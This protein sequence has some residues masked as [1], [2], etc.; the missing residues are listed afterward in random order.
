MKKNLQRFG[1]SVLAAAMV[2][3]SVALPAA[4]ETTKIDSSVAQSVAASAA[5]A[6]SAVQS[7][8]KF[9]S[10]ADLIKQTAQTL[11]AQGEVHELE[12]DDAKLEATAQ[13]KAGMSL[14]ALEN[15][16]ADAMY[17]NAAAGKINTEAYGLN[18]DEMASVMAA[19]IKTYHLSSAVTDLGYETNAAGVVTAVTFTGSSGMTSAM[20]SMTNSDDEVIA[21]QAD[22]YAQAYVAENSDTFAA[23]A[24]ADGHTYGEPKWYWNDTNPEDGHTHT[25]KETPDGY[26][27]KTDDGWAYTAVYT[28]KE[29]DAY[30]K[31]EGTV[32]KD[33]TEAKPGAAGKTVYS[34][35]VPADKSP[36]KKEYKEPTTRTDDIA[37][38][39]C[40]NHAVPKDA[41]GNFVA[42]FNWEM[43]KVEG[44]LEADYSNAQLFYDS[45]TGKISASAPVTIDWE[46]TSV[47]FKCAV[48]GE[49]IKT[50]PVMTMPVSVVVDQNNNS[51]Y[52]N[53]GGT[54]TLD[55]TSGGTG[56]TLVSAMDGGNWYDM[57]NNPVDASKVNFTY[58]S[59]DNK[60]KNSLLL[61]DS[62]KTAVYVDDQ[63]NQV[64]N[65]YDV[66]TAQMNY[67]YFQLSQ[68][69]QDEAEYFGVVAPFWTSKGVQKQGEDG[70]ITGTM[71][72]I[73]VLCSM[74][75]NDDVPPTTMAFMLNMLPQAFMAYV[76]NYG[77]ALKAI[78]DA[79]LAQVA[80]LG[81]SA[82]YVTKLLILHDWISQVAEFDMGS[83]GDITGGGNNDP[84]QMT[85]FGALLGG[86]IGASGVEYGCICLGYASAFNYM[87]QNLPDNKS[88]YKNEDG[89]WKTPDEVGDN[90]VVDFAQILYYCNT[91]DTSVAG[92]AFGGGMFNNVHY[93][94]AVKVNKLQGDSNSAT[95]TTGEAN[96]NWYYVDVC[97]DD[98]NT[99][100]MAQTRVE[101][102]GDLRHV[103]FLVSPSG[104]EG[105]YSK[106]YDYIDSLYDGYTY[107]KNKNPDVDDDGNVVLNNGKPHYSYT[108]TENK[109][110]TRYTDTCYEDTWFTSICSPIY[111]DN[112]Y[113]YYV[114]TTT[115]QNLYNNMRRQQSENGNNGN[116]GSGSSGNNSQMQQFMKKMQ[117]QGP[118]TLEARPRN[119]NYYIRK[120][121]SSSRPGGFSMS[122]FTKTDDPFDIVLMYYNDLKETSSNFNDDDSNAKVLAEA[123]TIYKIDT[124]AKDKHA[125][126]E[127]NLNTECLADAAAKR[128]YPALVHSTALYDGKLYFNVNNA[129]YRMDPTTGTV[130]EVKEY[131]TVYGGIK[132]TK[133]KDGNMVPDTHFPGMSM[134]IMDSAQDTSSVKYLGTFKNHPLA[135]LTL[136]DSYSFAT[137]T[138]QKQTV[139]TGINTTKDQLVVSVGTNLSNTY[140]SLDELDSDGKPVVKTDV[141][142]TSYANRKSY[143]TESWNYNPSYNQN[144]GS[145][146]EK[147]K[148]EEFM[149]CAN[150]VETMPMS[151]MVSD[152][153]SGA[154]TDVSVEAWCDTPAYTQARTTKY[155]L[156]KGK[157]VYADN[158]L[159][160]GH[161]W[162]LDE[163][164][165]KSVGNN[166][167]LCSDC[168]T[169]TES[170][171]HTV[172]LPDA[173]AGVTLTLGTTSNTYIKDDTV[174]LTVE[175]EGTDI[176]T[177][178]AKNGDTEVALTEVQEAA[179]DEAAAQA[180]T[181]K[182]KTVY[183]FTMPDGDVTISVEKNAKTYEVK[184]AETTNGKLEISPATAAE[185]ATVT[186]KVTPDAGY[187]LK[188]NG[189][190]VT[191]TDA[192][193]KE[194]TVEVKAGTEANTYT[195][196][197]PAYP[198]NVS[199]EFAKEYKVTVADT[200]NK[201]GETKVSATA[202]VVGTEVTV[203]VKAADNYQLKADSLTYSYKSGEDTKTEKL[204][205]NAE[206]KATFKMPAADVKVT[207]EY[208]EKK[209]EAYT[210]TVNK[211][212]NGTVTV[213]KATNGTVTADKETAAAGDTVTL[214]VEADETMYS[215]AVLAEDGLKV[216]DSKGAAVACTAG[217]DGTYTFTMP[218]DN[219]TVTATFEIVAYGVEVAP[220][221]HGSVTFEGGKKYFKVGENVTATFTAEAGYELASASYQEGNKPTDITAKVKEASN[222]YTF[223]MPENYVKIEATF[224]AVQ[225]TEPTE[226]TEPTTPDENGGDNTETEALEAEERTVHGAAE[227]TTITAMAV[228]TCTD[229]NCASA[230]FVDATVKQTSGVTTAAVNFNGKDYTAKY[231]EKNGW[232]EENGKKYWYEKGVKQG[233]TGRGKEIYD[234]DSDAWYW[235][236]A[237]QGG[238]MT[239]S[240][241]VYQ[242]SAAGQWAD[243]PDGTGKWVRYDENGHMVKGWQTTDKGTYYFDLITGAMAKG[244]GDIDGVPCAFDE[245]TGIAL[246]GQWLTIKGADF[247]YEKGVRQGLDGRGKEIYD[248]ASDAWYWLD[249]VDQGKKATSKDVYQESEAGQWADR[250]DGTGKWL[251]YD[252]QGHMIKGWSADKRYYFDPIYGTMAKGDA[253][254]D[255]RTY[256]FDKNTGVL[257]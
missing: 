207:A 214:T 228:F 7:L 93:F 204:T 240:K 45:E 9:T 52:I 13:S 14:A 75:P 105:R 77:E 131:N 81:D 37:A 22:S 232:V 122:S 154:T 103:N 44:K 51:V 61:Y 24:A 46:C 104:L 206:G 99:E 182:A 135:G 205:P 65:T 112:N 39:P 212:T 249:A 59:G 18:K 80:K 27:T 120:E 166:V 115:N 179:Q 89:S 183:T 34:A 178:T 82:D 252:A 149:W 223:T 73:K 114:D 19:T 230:Q 88:I 1:A 177:V 140:K 28:C 63:G 199:A 17:A 56:V 192:D 251:R 4:A 94:N 129:I 211:A 241:D 221:E 189:L 172:T 125:K 138:Q 79:G 196:A 200:A 201:N 225:P 153:N 23:S 67:Y 41:D 66:S 151:D 156:T 171:P 165:T 126:V 55:T 194:Q 216:A 69:N 16:L 42:T 48:C 117:N 238:A 190:K 176:V 78:R 11:A 155:G 57:Q 106:Y 102:A 72:A 60:G 229:K 110:E 174:T 58:Q 226:P 96:K 175:K 68:F 90:A 256:H 167:Y 136:R 250:A 246:D 253:V 25:W 124:S 193:N 2:A 239:V 123:G 47:T 219:V 62:Q 64:T 244:A 243:K 108:K 150:L 111:F 29:G 30:Q 121:D 8:P 26:W 21:Q 91:S 245:Y 31:V 234:P 147:N 218:A 185:G 33:T 203:T 188:E 143:K 235:L 113:F 6:A 35:S 53:V 248:P 84:I 134:V 242:E 43:K 247:W 49:E 257:Q 198:V 162:A 180:T 95:M 118:D 128:I 98:V 83:M 222:T 187:A 12:Q 145:S 197:M 116:S 191:Y 5:S 159:P 119:A 15:A 133:D 168:H 152:L 184:Q 20:E 139:I 144:M 224:T 36:V 158:A 254:I 127:N 217:A 170:T 50:Q 70:S 161:T 32:T 87:V 208:V 130:E 237:V 157:K 101:N 233:T 210:V 107:T 109:N 97:Y 141:S 186:V 255:G 163:L 148:N 76:M 92:N 195:F 215:Q 227:K 236:D 38:L 86:G 209:P 85:A 71:G 74:D 181:E 220:T 173:V 202:A 164:E 100:C 137:T 142:G 160:K 132:L 231:G 3:Q 213:N 54:P 40:Q 146:D 10:T 169:A